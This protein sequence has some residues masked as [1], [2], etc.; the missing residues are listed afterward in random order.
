DFSEV[1]KLYLLYCFRLDKIKTIGFATHHSDSFSSLSGVW[2]GYHVPFKLLFVL[3]WDAAG[4]P[5]TIQA[6]FRPRLGRGGD[7]THHSGYFS[8]SFGARRMHRVSCRF[9]FIIVWG[10]VYRFT[11]YD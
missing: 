6:L 2:R 11:T 5:R 3:V 7:P 4:L 1:S 10:A 9:S 8:S